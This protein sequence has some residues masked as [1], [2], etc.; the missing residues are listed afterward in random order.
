MMIEI[1]NLSKQ[2]MVPT[3]KKGLFGNKKEPFWAVDSLDFTVEKGS[4][5]S[6]LG[7]WMR[8]D[9]YIKNDCGNAFSFTRYSL[10]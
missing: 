1:K 9:N 7:K 3:E 8:Q 10:N 2:F 4:V 5:V 6:I